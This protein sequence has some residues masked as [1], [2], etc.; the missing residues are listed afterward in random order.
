MSAWLVT[1]VFVLFYGGCLQYGTADDHYINKW[2]VHVPGGDTEADQLA[3][4]HG[5]HNEG[6]VRKK[7]L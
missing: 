6:Q 1:Q 2:A 7:I 4:D 5:F 3:H